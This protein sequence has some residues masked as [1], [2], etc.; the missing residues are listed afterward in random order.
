MK[1]LPLKGV[2]VAATYSGSEAHHI[3]L[4]DVTD[5]QWHEECG[6]MGMVPTIRV[7]K[8]DELFSEHP[9]SNVLGVYYLQDS[10]EVKP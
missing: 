8:D 2:F 5:V 7:Y 4:Q 3:G 6:Q 9:F 10:D 1:R